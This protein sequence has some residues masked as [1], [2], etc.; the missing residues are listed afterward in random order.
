MILDF[1]FLEVK[2]TSH[3]KTK[4]HKI[5]LKKVCGL[6]ITV[7]AAEI[8][9]ELQTPSSLSNLQGRV[10]HSLQVPSSTISLMSSLIFLSHA[11]QLPSLRLSWS[12]DKGQFLNS[13]FRK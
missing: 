13:Y 11:W 2:T 5:R 12:K 8:L 6:R 10:W 1:Y 9:A 7:K 4:E 3:Q